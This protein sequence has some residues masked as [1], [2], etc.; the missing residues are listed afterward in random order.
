M[1]F[2][3]GLEI[4]KIDRGVST[5]WVISSSKST[6]HSGRY[7][8]LGVTHSVPF[9]VHT[10]ILYTRHRR[11]IMLSCERAR[12]FWVLQHRKRLPLKHDWIFFT[13][14]IE[15]RRENFLPTARSEPAYP[16]TIV[17]GTDDR[18]RCATLGYN[19]Y[20]TQKRLVLPFQDEGFRPD[21]GASWFQFAAA[22]TQKLACC[23]C[24]GCLAKKQRLSMLLLLSLL[25]IP[26]QTNKAFSKRKNLMCFLSNILIAQCTFI[27]SNH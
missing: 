3:G 17:H 13:I 10:L 6:V 8:S 20:K 1:A 16:E 18:Y 25:Q 24:S 12:K 23:C 19:V 2:S 15:F 4:P 21:M 14:P 9:N 27:V 26:S 11:L 7:C 22:P 5:W